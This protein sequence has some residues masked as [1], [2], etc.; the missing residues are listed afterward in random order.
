[1]VWWLVRTG[2]PREELLMQ[3][4]DVVVL[5]PGFLRFTRFGGSYY[6]AGR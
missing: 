4:P 6:F 2:P 1:M 3:V 5:V